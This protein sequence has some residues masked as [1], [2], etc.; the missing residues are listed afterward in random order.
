MAEVEKADGPCG[1]LVVDK[2]AG[3]TSHDVV[4]RVRRLL[5]TRR[6]GH[7]GTLDP[8]ATGVLV[9]LAGNATRL[10]DRLA[11]SKKMYEAEILLGT[12]TDTQDSTG[13]ILSETSA[14]GVAEEAF[15]RILK[16]FEGDQ[17]QIP[18]MVSAIHSNG[19]RLYELARLGVE[20]ERKPRPVLIE[21]ITLLSFTPGDRATARI[22]VHC[23]AGTYIRTLA[24]DIGEALGC[25]ACMSAL[26]RISSGRF[27]ISDARTLKQLEAMSAQCPGGV[28]PVPVARALHDI[29]QV[30]LT[31]ELVR[32]IRFGRSLPVPVGIAFSGEVL[33]LNSR[34]VALSLA[35]AEEERLHPCRW[36]APF[37]IEAEVS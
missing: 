28:I 27:G 36:I 9:L 35:L 4:N 31:D 8:M 32:D 14:E 37:G 3:M 10:A 33:L 12:R 16:R 30:R 26:R 21:E 1:V 15:T 11:A 25:G 5:G 13:H 29:P 2:P 34:G 22:R 23:S 20:V 7:A 6:V 24:S 18:P 17:T 19:K